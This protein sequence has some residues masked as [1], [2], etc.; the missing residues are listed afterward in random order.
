MA[1][2]LWHY[3]GDPTPTG[4]HNFTDVPT[5]SYYNTA[6]AW[7]VGAGITGGTSPGTY[8]PN[9][10]VTRAQMA[11]FLWKYSCP[12][13]SPSLTLAT[14][15]N[16]TCALKPD[17]T[18]K[19]WGSNEFGQMG[20][21][22]AGGK[23]PSPTPVE[24]LT[25]ITAITAG[26]AHTCALTTNRTVTCWGYN[27]S[28]Q[29]GDGTTNNA[30]LTPTPVPGLGNVTA[31]TA[32]SDHTCAVTSDRTVKCWGA[33]SAGQVGDGTTSP[34]LTPTPVVALT[35]VTAITA[36]SDHTCATTR[37]SFLSTVKCWGNNEQGQLGDGTTTR[38][39]T[40][41]E[42]TGLTNVT[43]TITS[44]GGHTCA[45]TTSGTATCWGSNYWGELGDGTTGTNRLTPTAVT[46]LTNT[47]T[48]TAGG[49]HTCATT[50]SGTTKCW[51]YNGHGQVGDGTTTQRPTPTA[52]TGLTNAATITAG[53]I[54]TCA[55]TT[56]GTATCWGRNEYG[57][58][59]DGTTGTNR[60]TPTPVAGL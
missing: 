8:S 50:T 45:T 46:G 56:S 11:V 44:G 7:L 52:V 53:T 20:G 9:N 28:G 58:V 12:P 24:G 38:R 43:A 6:V 39:L 22:T 32:G 57:Q 47:A 18:V 34:R 29:I 59:G 55:T 15:Q 35:N 41:T 21:G 60:L 40:P 31:I 51:G 33:N 37:Y 23:R 16:H 36:G 48:I 10:P 42:I 2:F 13:P 19:C 3:D 27:G 4:P 14:G 30:R 26:F 1:V 49:G 25:D 54:H 5:T 17:A